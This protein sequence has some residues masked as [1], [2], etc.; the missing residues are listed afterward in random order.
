MWRLVR[1][2]CS[3]ILSPG[4]RDIYRQSVVT[5]FSVSTV[6]P[7]GKPYL[8]GYS[9]PDDNEHWQAENTGKL[10]AKPTVEQNH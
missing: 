1:V 3:G 8:K 4:F 7:R 2:F 5:L 6:P 9:F 10:A